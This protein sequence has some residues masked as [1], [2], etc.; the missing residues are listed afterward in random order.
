LST[1]PL[2]HDPRLPI[3]TIGHSNQSLSTFLELL[4]GRQIAVLGDV[5][6]RPYSRYAPQFNAPAL[7]PA[8]TAA[9]IQYLHL[10][11]LGGRP[12]GPEFYDAAG[13]VVY[14]LVEQAPF[15][16]D[17]IARLETG[18][19]KYRIAL[20]CSEED[21][22]HCHRHLLVSRVLEARGIPVAHILGDG[23]LLAERDLAAVQAQ[24]ARPEGQ[25]PLFDLEETTVW[26]STR[27]VLR[28]DPRPPSSE[29]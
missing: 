9:G 21:P 10:P 25:P 3:F 7:K 2:V 19:R 22:A 11:Q 6:S 5:R 18:R 29:R 14:S 15:F 20:M 17:G 23:T 12:D 8:L 1:T 16:L 27:S 26:K 13:H 24:A 4:R 28:K